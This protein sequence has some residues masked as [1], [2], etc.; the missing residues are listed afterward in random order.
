M[1]S[2]RYYICKCI[3]ATSSPREEE[4]MGGDTT[5]KKRKIRN[6]GGFFVDFNTVRRVDER[7]NSQ[8][9][10]F[11]AFH[12]NRFIREVGLNELRMGGQ[13][14][15]Y[16]C[17]TDIKPHKLDR[18]LVCN[19]FLNAFPSTSITALPYEISYHCPVTLKTT[20][21]EFGKPPF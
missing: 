10:P 13:H 4:I 12:F 21:H 2:R 17:Q 16:F 5:N 1:Y 20:S 14:F 18:F 7:Y 3:W 6:M 8:C 11:Y 15:T 19:N 9:H